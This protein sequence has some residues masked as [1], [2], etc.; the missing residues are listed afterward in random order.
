MNF[1][2]RNP[3]GDEAEFERCENAYR[4]HLQRFEKDTR[5]HL[6]K[7]FG[8]DFFHDGSIESIEVRGDLKTVGDA[9]HLSE[10]KAVQIQR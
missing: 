2:I 1:R 6:W 7:F 8:W 9:A 4:Q 3:D 10:H 5:T